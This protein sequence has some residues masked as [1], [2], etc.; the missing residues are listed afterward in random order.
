MVFSMRDL[1]ANEKE[2]LARL[3]DGTP[4]SDAGVDRLAFRAQCFEEIALIDRLEAEGYIR[5]DY[6][7]EPRVVVSGLDLVPSSSMRATDA[8]GAPVSMA[9]ELATL[10]ISALRNFAGSRR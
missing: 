8:T 4:G 6:R 2:L 5:R 7:A 1:S 9:V 10:L 3:L